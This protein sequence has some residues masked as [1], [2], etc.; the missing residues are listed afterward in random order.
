[1]LCTQR[2][3][4]W[5]PWMPLPH[6]C[7]SICCPFVSVYVF[8][9]ERYSKT[10]PMVQMRLALSTQTQV[11]EVAPK[12]SHY[13]SGTSFHTDKTMSGGYS[14]SPCPSLSLSVTVFQ[15]R[16]RLAR[17]NLHLHNY[18][19]RRSRPALKSSQRT[20]IIC[21]LTLRLWQPQLYLRDWFNF[22]CFRVKD[23][24]QGTE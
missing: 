16:G 7:P 11:A 1:M 24:E 12:S 4:S 17:A 10:C 22:F 8:L 19:W 3:D 2:G 6:I 15:P 18:R 14:D 13:L 20:S 21:R 5:Q 23:E 9:S